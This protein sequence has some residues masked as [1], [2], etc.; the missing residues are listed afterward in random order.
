MKPVDDEVVN[1]IRNNGRGSTIF[2]DD[3]LQTLRNN[4]NQWYEMA[5]TIDNDNYNRVVASYVSSARYF[6]DKLKAS[7]NLDIEFRSSQSRKD[8][9]ARLYVRVIGETNNGTD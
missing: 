5:S 3:N 2:S 8:K 1:R 4:P 6:R 7:D 9:S